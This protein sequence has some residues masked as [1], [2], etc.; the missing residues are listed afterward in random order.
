V[1]Q[2]LSN[3][4]ASAMADVATKERVVRLAAP[5]CDDEIARVLSA[6]LCAADDQKL[7]TVVVL[8]PQ[9]TEIALAIRD[10]LKRASS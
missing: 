6:A 9:G 7:W 10:R 2:F 5:K 4:C 8:Q 3:C 1:S